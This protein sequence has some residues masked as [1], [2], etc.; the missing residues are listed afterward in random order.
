MA[1]SAAFSALL[2]GPFPAA[3]YS[4][5][6][7]PAPLTGGRPHQLLLCPL[8]F[9]P[10]RPLFLSPSL[11]LDPPPPVHFVFLINPPHFTQILE[12]YPIPPCLD[13]SLFFFFF[14]F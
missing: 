14:F 8:P 5:L 12:F 9:A 1:S 7:K 4:T 13:P 10:I 6:C 3:H 11:A 2:S